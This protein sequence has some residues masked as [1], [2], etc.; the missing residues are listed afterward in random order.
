MVEVSRE[1]GVWEVGTAR[2]AK[3]KGHL[4]FP[5]GTWVTASLLTSVSQAAS[6]LTLVDKALPR[7]DAEAMVSREEAVPGLP[8]M[9]CL[10]AAF[11]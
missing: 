8:E 2:A 9:I 1:A 4:H 7:E 11:V 10:Y 5:R 6:W 3:R